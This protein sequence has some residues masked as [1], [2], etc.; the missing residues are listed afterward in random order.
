MDPHSVRTF[1]LLEAAGAVWVLGLARLPEHRIAQ[2]LWLLAEG[3]RRP[4]LR[5]DRDQRGCLSGRRQAHWIGWLGGTQERRRA[6]AIET[7]PPLLEREREL[8]E[9]GSALTEARQGRGQVVLIEASAGLGKTSLLR[10]ACQ[11]ATAAGFTCLRARA[12]EL[13]RDLPSGACGSCWSPR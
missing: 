7:P 5:R 6:V 1:A 10:V 9:L 3:A 8:A 4:T 13:E 2:A 11:A 12:S